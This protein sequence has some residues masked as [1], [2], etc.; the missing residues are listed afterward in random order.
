MQIDTTA[1]P[2]KA[3]LNPVYEAETR[4]STGWVEKCFVL[5][6]FQSV[7]FDFDFFFFVRFRL[8]LAHSYLF[9]RRWEET[10]FVRIS[11]QFRFFLLPLLLLLANAPF[12]FVDGNCHC[13]SRRGRQNA[14]WRQ[15]RKNAEYSVALPLHRHHERRWDGE[16][17]WVSEPYA[18]SYGRLTSNGNKNGFQLLEIVPFFI[19]RFYASKM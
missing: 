16:C 18:S 15:R 5:S 12:C 2:S 19:Y 3:R 4:A 13:G 10:K 17:S 1:D 6:F 7:V 11:F 14:F 9:A 8:A